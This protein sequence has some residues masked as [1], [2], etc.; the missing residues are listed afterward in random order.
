MTCDRPDAAPATGNDPALEIILRGPGESIRWAKH[1]YPHHLAKWHRH[2]E[3]ELHLVTAGRGR[4]MVGDYVGPFQ[5]GCLVLAGPNLPHNWISDLD[6]GGRLP[7][8]DVLVQF[9]A[10]VCETLVNGFSEFADLRALLR[11]AAFGVEFHGETA[12]QGRRKLCAMEHQRGAGRLVAFLS[13]LAG[14]AARPDERRV[15]ARYAPSLGLHTSASRRLDRVIAFISERFATDISLGEAAAVCNME[16]TAFSRFFKHQTGHNFTSY[17]NRMRVQQACALL[18]G[19]DLPVTR[20]CYDVGYNNTANFNRQF[21]AVCQQT[22]SAY[23]DESRRI[24]THRT[25]ETRAA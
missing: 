5:E 16:V 18:T 4:M 21:Y 11:D 20:I 9:D 2:P 6:P 23:R 3:Y 17:V 8:R 12:E 7:N 15:L 13:L 1:D 24:R 19:T 22:P 14:L 10:A 25:G